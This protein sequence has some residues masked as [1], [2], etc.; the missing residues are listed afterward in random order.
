MTERPTLDAA[1]AA[2]AKTE[3][4]GAGDAD[5]LARI[6]QHAET[7]ASEPAHA[8]RKGFLPR[9]GW[10]VGGALAA[11]LVLALLA[12]P[13][14]G[15]GPGGGQAQVIVAKADGAERNPVM[16]AEANDSESAA[17]ALL[18]TPTVEEEYQL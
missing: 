3:T 10:M 11:S 1:I 16:L 18:Y 12:T 7:I 8:A 14:P 9:S 4:D 2:W 13:R 15:A 17:F 5:A 6:L